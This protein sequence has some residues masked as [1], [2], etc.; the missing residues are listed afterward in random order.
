ME[1]RSRFVDRRIIK[2]YLLTALVLFVGP[3]HAATIE[4]NPGESIQNAIDKANPEDSVVVAAGTYTEN[5]EVNKKLTL[6]G[7]NWP[8]V[9]A[10]HSGS[11]INISADGCVI[12]GLNAANSSGWNQAG[13]RVTSD[14]NAIYNN[15][16]KSNKIG[17]VLDNSSSNM[18]SGSDAR[19]GGIGILLM[20][21]GNNTIEGNKAS[22]LG[23][24]DFGM[25]SGIYLLGS[26]NYNTVDGN[27]I[28]T[29]GIMNTGILI[30]QSEGNN[31]TDNEVTGSGWIS[32]MGIGLLECD[33]CLIK[34]NK[35][36]SDGIFGQGIRLMS[37]HNNTISENDVSCCGPMGQAIL[38]LQSSRNRILNNN[39]RS[40]A[41][42]LD[43]EFEGAW[44]N[45]LSGNHAIR[46]NG[47]P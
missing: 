41:W 38:I 9:Q 23:K 44:S 43:M 3:V 8:V 37:A 29:S 33:G 1:N 22:S 34:N 24:A 26:C 21:S 32:G 5:I 15:V 28:E 17:I 36:V 4:V 39:A 47:D 2:I 20:D 13:I 6:S 25:S 42:G 40:R 12:K 45:I 31:V 19:N 35:V 14:N 7:I 46:I 30:G 27:I 10:Q 18:I 11:A 16:V